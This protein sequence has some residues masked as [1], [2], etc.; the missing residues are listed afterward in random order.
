MSLFSFFAVLAFDNESEK[1][2]M[3]LSGPITWVVVLFL[4]CLR[5]TR[6]YFKFRNVRSLLVCPNGELR[7]INDKKADV[8]RE[9]ADRK[10]EFPNFNTHPEWNV[11]D[12]NKCFTFFG[13][14]N[15][16]YSPKK[17]WTQYEKISNQD[18]KYAKAHLADKEN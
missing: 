17:V 1:L 18:Y 5:K 10:Y 15:M 7:Y 13:C 3:I 12:W 2:G 9:C 14:G 16:R 11:K 8:M 4:S 6:D